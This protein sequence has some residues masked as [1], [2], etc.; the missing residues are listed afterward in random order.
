MISRT[1]IDLGEDLSTGKLI[2]KNVDV[3][4]WIFV[5]DSNSIQGLIIDTASKIDLSSSQTMLDS[6]KVKNSDRYALCQI[7]PSIV[8]SIQLTPS[9]SSFMVVWR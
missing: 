1:K 7:I 3:G 5:L 4:Q 8:S 2:K 9:V 6:P